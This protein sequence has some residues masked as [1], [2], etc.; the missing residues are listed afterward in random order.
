MQTIEF[1]W[2]QASQED[3]FSRIELFRDGLF[4][5]SSLREE[6]DETERIY[7][8]AGMDVPPEIKKRHQIRMAEAFLKHPLHN[9]MVLVS[10]SKLLSIEYDENGQPADNATLVNGSIGGRF[11]GLCMTQFITPAGD[12]DRGLALVVECVVE[13]TY[14]EG[15]VLDQDCRILM[16]VNDDFN[17]EPIDRIELLN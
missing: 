14:P 6:L 3:P 2:R 1:N 13:V 17:C 5:F 15:D 11:T 12:F 4:S 10:G 8:E 16:P 7:R 9:R